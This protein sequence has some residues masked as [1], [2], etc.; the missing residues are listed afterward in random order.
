MQ[1]IY[2]QTYTHARIQHTQQINIF[3]R[4]FSNI[5]FSN[6][7]VN[8]IKVYVDFSIFS[9]TNDPFVMQ[10]AIVNLRLR[11]GIV[12]AWDKPFKYIIYRLYWP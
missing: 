12:F 1:H 2:L 6:A 7:Q 8:I 5:F 9:V 4:K 11:H 3:R 10:Y